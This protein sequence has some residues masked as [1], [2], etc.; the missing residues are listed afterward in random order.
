MSRL[1]LAVLSFL[2]IGSSGAALAD[3]GQEC[4]NSSGEA[5]IQA[6]DQAIRQNPRDAVSHHN[7]GVVYFHKGDFDLAIADFSE[8]IEINPKMAMAY[9]ARGVI[10]EEKGDFDRAIADATKA[11]EIDPK[12]APA[13]SNRGNALKNKGGD[14][15]R[16]IG[17]Y[18]RSIEID[19]LQQGGAHLNA[20]YGRGFAYQMKRDL[21]RAM[22]DYTRAI[23]VDPKH[24]LAYIGRG[25]ILRVRGDLDGAIADDTKAIE[26]DPAH[27]LPYI[28]R[29]EAYQDKSEVDRALADYA[30]A[31]EIDPKSAA[32]YNSR[33]RFRVK[34]NLDLPLA[35][36]DC[37]DA[38]RLAPN[39]AIF[40]DNRGFVYLKL[41]RIDEAIAD[42]D[43]A[44]KINPKLPGS[45]YGRG[46]ARQKKGDQAGGD[47]D[48]A[49]AKAIKAAI[50]D[51]FAKYGVD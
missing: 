43:A 19:P 28:R 39:N 29:A 5:A 34:A 45:L 13:Y 38:V 15:D 33:C 1:Y 48:I 44:L 22:T 46:L 35:L 11:I 12:Y 6:C 49:A 37:D 14:L 25:F 16:A 18:T 41:D 21:D 30:K 23:D 42:Y 27:A 31:I 7:R 26:V 2:L 40:M 47:A 9:N 50:A 4:D 20:Y 10:F 8:A 51:E 36:A 24:A 32:A 3:A 17:D